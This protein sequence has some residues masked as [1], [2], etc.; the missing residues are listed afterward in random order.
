MFG[1]ISY[2]RGVWVVFVLVS[3]ALDS[4]AEAHPG[5]GSFPEAVVALGGVAGGTL[6]AA[7]AG[8][9]DG[10]GCL[11]EDFPIEADWWRQDGGPD[12]RL[13]LAG[14]G[15]TG[16]VRTMVLRVLDEVGEAGS[17]LRGEE[18]R[19]GRG[20]GSGDDA[21]WLR[22]YVRAAS[23][24]REARLG[25]ARA[26]A[27]KVVFTK[28]RTM[29]PS[30]FAYTE[31]QSDA[32]HERHFMPGSELCLLEWDGPRVQVRTLLADPGGVLRDP[33]V[34]WDGKRI[35]FAW[36]R[37]LD[38][39][40]YHLYEMDVASGRVRQL[41]SGLGF[42]DYE[43]AYL[44]SGDIIFSSTRC[45]QTVDCWWTEVSNL[46]T[47]DGDGRF[48]RRLGFDQVH[49]IFPTVLGDGRVIYTR[50][51]Y[52]D[53]GQIFPQALFQMNPDGTGQSEFYGNSS[54]FPTTIAHA[55]GIP[56]TRRVLAI[57]CG[58]HSTQAG[59]LAIIDPA[60][61]RQEN[62]GVQLVAPERETRAERID[63]YGQEG[64]LFQYP[65]PLDEREFL[66][67]FAPRGWD[68]P[69]KKDRR[70]GDAA[71]GIYWMDVA[72]RRELLVSDPGVACQQ[73][74]PLVARPRPAARPSAV[75]HR[76]TEGTCYVQDV[77]AGPG[78]AGV[79]RGSVKRLRVVAIDFRPAGVGNNGSRGPGG[80]A[81][82]STPV[83]VGNG[84]WDAKI[85]LGEARVHEDG[86][87]FFF[88]PARTPIYFQAIDEKG[89]ALQ[90]MRSW[91]TLQPGENQSCV[92]CHEHKNSA[93]SIGDYRGGLALQA[94]P[95]ALTPF[96]GPA[97]GFSFPREIQ[98]ILDRHCVGCHGDRQK[99]MEAKRMDRPLHC[100][101]DPDW[102]HALA[103]LD[104]VIR[105]IA[106]PAAPPAP[107]AAGQK[108]FSL[109]GDTTLDGLAKRHW[110]DAYL[111]LT[112][113]LPANNDWDRGSFAGQSDGLMVNWIGSQSIPA[114]LPPCI[115]GSTRSGLLPLLE[116]GHGGV[117]LAREELEKIACW[118]D[119]FVP[120]CGDYTES[121]AWTEEEMA[122]YRRYLEKRRRMEAEER[123]NIEELI[124][125]S[126]IK[127]DGGGVQS[128]LAPLGVS[129]WT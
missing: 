111:N 46:Y 114:P 108:A 50:W 34:S 74:V 101:T 71:F 126:D 117:Q 66:V 129:P 80:G 86:S 27:P 84:A 33:A 19:L 123:G 128:R 70:R 58:H 47:C 102:A 77:Y 12:F 32:Q 125:T 45:V 31:G 115:A 119:L 75:D 94:G 41:T 40:D 15:V 118:I 99:R 54:W 67:G 55:R 122:K 4:R 30:F 10:P 53:R 23:V 39:D 36:K 35:L 81:L 100:E 79:P 61:G 72:G 64:E 76:K 26:R 106:P 11:D 29:R 16:A 110:S 38:A 78:L 92:G 5:D 17:A 104:A 59:K 22:L 98:P 103:D 21:G 1:P 93:P 51:D 3:C 120:Y 37:S 56:E 2:V 49:T 89:R 116:G 69:G 24:R 25:E 6:G 121:N 20:T 87:A 105:G 28:R 52:N 8:R 90:T 82:I 83:A 60:V 9:A 44:P 109:R 48:L 42:A 113:A 14:S 73:P 57:L 97:R 88:V 7:S 18:A 112:L 96:H 43:P 124:K 63:A 65:Y 85:V 68:N 62:A 95:Q 91:T 107:V 127:T 13:L